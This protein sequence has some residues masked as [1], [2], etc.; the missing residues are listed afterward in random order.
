MPSIFDL[1]PYRRLK[2]PG[3]KACREES[4]FELIANMLPVTYQEAFPSF[5]ETEQRHVHITELPAVMNYNSVK[6]SFIDPRKVQTTYS[7]LS[8]KEQDLSGIALQGLLF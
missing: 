3:W 2:N 1:S 6:C 7:P 8:S 4:Y 5:T